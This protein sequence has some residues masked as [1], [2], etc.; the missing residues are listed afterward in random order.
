[1]A[2]LTLKDAER[3]ATKGR[4]WT[5]RLEFTGANSANVSGVSD[6]FWYA[7]GRALTEPVE[8]GWGANGRT[9]QTQLT[10]W[11]D[12]RGRVADKLAKGYIYA[13][14]P[15]IRMH[16]DNIAKITAGQ[17][18]A[19]MTPAQVAPVTTVVSVAP[20]SAVAP[21]KAP[22]ASLAGLGVPWNMIDHLQVVRK[23]TTI[24]GYKAIDVAGVE[25]LEFTEDG[26]R[27]FAKDH[28]LDI[29]W[30]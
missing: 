8:V 30:K 3:I 16:P 19:L 12:L 18:M 22:K 21:V 25:I 7:T 10:D 14:T 27:Q 29:E 15:F 11:N 4:P 20:S 17:F 1:M 28:D 5:F 23:N 9:P 6:K 24:L 2:L 13:S 26:G